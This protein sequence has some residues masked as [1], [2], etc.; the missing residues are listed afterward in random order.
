[1]CVCVIPCMGRLPPL[2]PPSPCHLLPVAMH[3]HQPRLGPSMAQSARRCCSNG[4]VCVGGGEGGAEEE[5]R[6]AAPVLPS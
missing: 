2:P 6:P 3:E 5:V 4:V 1:M